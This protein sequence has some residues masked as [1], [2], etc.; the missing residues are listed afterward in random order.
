MHR[1]TADAMYRY[2]DTLYTFKTCLKPSLIMHVYST[3]T[4]AHTPASPATLFKT[5]RPRRPRQRVQPNVFVQH[6]GDAGQRFLIH[7]KY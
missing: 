6:A 1:P 5:H 4:Y 7:V 2:T 3:H